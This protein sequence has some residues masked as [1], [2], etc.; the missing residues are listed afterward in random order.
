MSSE[1]RAEV[2]RDQQLAARDYRLN[3]RL[4]EACMPD[5]AAHCKELEHTCSRDKGCSGRVLQCLRAH[6]D[7]LQGEDCKEEVLYFLKM[8]VRPRAVLCQNGGSP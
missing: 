8:E 6:V 4:K 3:F 5:V 2:Q 1:C 7:E